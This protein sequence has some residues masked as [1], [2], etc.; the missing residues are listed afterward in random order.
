VA[1]PTF[2]LPRLAEIY[3]DLD[4][5]RDDLGH[6]VSMAGELRAG[7]VLDIGCGTGEFALR[8]ADAGVDVTGVDPA[9]ASLDVA[10]RKPGADRVRWVAGNAADALPISVDLVTMTGNVAQ[11]FTDDEAWHE[12]L[13]TARRAL[14]DGGH[15]V[16][17]VRDPAMRAWEDWTPEASRSTTDTVHGPVESWVELTEVS[18]ALVSFRWTFHFVRDD[19]LLVSDSTLLFRSR[20]EVVDSL[21]RAGLVVDE[22]RDAPDRPGRELVFITHR[23]T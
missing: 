2:S 3:D 7:S 9:V 10:R 17:E 5:R 6:Y 23:A 18:S 15:L 1:D 11:V 21:D 16:F 20:T 22:I 13:T 14:A 8:L 19:T 4:G 12:T